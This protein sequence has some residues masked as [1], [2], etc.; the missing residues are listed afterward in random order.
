[1]ASLVCGAGFGLNTTSMLIAVQISVPWSE[2]GIST[3]TLQFFRNMGNAAGAAIL[4]AILTATL[5]P[6]LA[7]TRIAALVN[8]MPPEALKIGSDPTLG[9]V[10]ALFDLAV[11]VLLS[12]ETRQALQDMLANS[13]WWVFFGMLVMAALAAIF[14][15]R[16]PHE[17]KPAE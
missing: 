14:V 13:L 1:V 5:A 8:N 2:R 9:P 6:Q 17:V 16:F 10:N 12:P 3:A 11:R 7:S 4:G 15:L